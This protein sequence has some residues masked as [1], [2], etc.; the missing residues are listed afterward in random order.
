M[1]R[2]V[3]ASLGRLQTDYVD[4]LYLHLDHNGMNLEAAAGAGRHVA[5]GKS[6]TG[7][8]P[9]PGLAHR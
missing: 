5:P 1:L 3:A 6:A 4:I 9:T 8:C 7:G 2:H